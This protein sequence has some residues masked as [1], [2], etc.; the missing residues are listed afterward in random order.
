MIS[1]AKY[2]LALLLCYLATAHASA[3]NP[4]Y[5]FRIRFTDKEATIHTLSSP[6]SYLSPR[7]L[8]RRARYNIP[9]DSSDLP[10]AATYVDSVLQITGGVLHTRSRWHNSCVILLE[11]SSAILGLQPVSFIRQIKQVAYYATGLHQKPG[12]PEE[13]SEAGKPTDFDENFYGQAWSQIHLCQGEYLHEQGY[14]GQDKLIAVIDVGFNGVNTAAPF[15]SLRQQ[16]RLMDTWNYIYDTAHVFGYSAHGCQVLSCMASYVPQS[17][18]GTAPKA[19]YA[20]Y[21]TDDQYSEQA[22]EEDNFAAAAER[23]D[24]L[25]ADLITTSLGYNTFD[26][27]DDSYTYADL[28]GKTTLAARTANAAVRKG[29]FMVAS[30]GNEGMQ[31]WQHI[32]TP[33]DADS[34]MTVGSVNN[35]KTY[36]PSSGKGPN[37]DGILKPNVAA[38]GV[39]AYVASPSGNIQSATGTSYATPVLAGLSACLLQAAPGM[40]PL[41]L[42]SLIESV[43]DSFA[44]PTY[45]VGNGVPDF[46]RAYETVG[47]E[48]ESKNTARGTF[49]VYPNPAEDRV[50]VLD[51]S[52][53][54][55]TT[56][57][58]IYTPDGRMVAKGSV[59]P[60]RSMNTGQLPRGLYLMQL[61]RGDKQQT[62][63]LL[64]R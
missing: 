10:V 19:M 7:A 58:R 60:G 51:R 31:A 22:I 48:E 47:I 27:P 38:Q 20:L 35:M 44:S 46:R 26:N 40:T 30:A 15:D 16:G 8:E 42:R 23:A 41:Q 14:M 63:K 54:N 2:S 50:Y 52:G 37:A 9:V 6:S 36:A 1:I 17:H 49:L 25:G 57:Y 4:Q 5:A 29:I 11:D 21:I 55:R 24:S 59:S 39:Q 32:L 34:A 3:Q 56:T 64:L 62:V 33:G 28:D 53:S 18:V 45:R 12:A 13:P 61:K 43:S